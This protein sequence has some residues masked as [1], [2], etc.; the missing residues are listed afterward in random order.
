MVLDE[1]SLFLKETYDGFDRIVDE[2]ILVSRAARRIRFASDRR[3]RLWG[4][5]RG[6]FANSRCELPIVWQHRA[7]RKGSFRIRLLRRRHLRPRMGLSVG[8][9]L[10]TTGYRFC[11]FEGCR[12]RG[13]SRSVGQ[14]HFVVSSSFSGCVDAP[15]AGLG[16]CVHDIH[17][18]RK[19]RSPPSDGIASTRGFVFSIGYV[20]PA[21]RSVPEMGHEPGPTE[22]PPK[23]PRFV[24]RPLRQLAFA[25]S[26]RAISAVHCST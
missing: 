7:L 5:G 25:R 2:A 8:Q 15:C 22:S 16:Q 24:P 17:R 13:T 9:L 21:W 11:E 18:E 12:E 3:H 23:Q 26:L 20:S 14:P 6:S 10:H 1:R 4:R 19:P